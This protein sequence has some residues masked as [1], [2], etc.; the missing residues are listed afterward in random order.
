LAASVESAALFERTLALSKKTAAP[1]EA[2]KN[3]RALRALAALGAGR[4]Q[5]SYDMASIFALEPQ[6]QNERYV[7]GMAALQLKR[8]DDA[9]KL[10]TTM[11]SYR[12]R[13]SLSAV[14]PVTHVLLARAHAGAGR[15][16]DARKAYDEAFKIWQD[17]DANLPLLIEA[18]KEYARLGS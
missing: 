5:D 12:G 16:V 1:E 10:F 15:T 13:T 4:Y 14:V 17:A 8:W 18:R 6:Y 3:E 9:T 11:L 7:A 2:I